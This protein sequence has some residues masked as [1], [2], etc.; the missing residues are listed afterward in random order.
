MHYFYSN[1]N[2]VFPSPCF[3]RPIKDEMRAVR[4]RA[5]AGQAI[6]QASYASG[7]LYRPIFRVFPE[8][9]PAEYVEGWIERLALKWKFNRSEVVHVKKNEGYWEVCGYRDLGDFWPLHSAHTSLWG[10]STKGMDVLP[11]AGLGGNVVVPL[12]FF[13]FIVPLLLVCKILLPCDL[14]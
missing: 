11:M 9:I 3:V 6:L 14:L 5:N 8:I 7:E 12:S 13:Y 4:V 10:R 2:C 1:H